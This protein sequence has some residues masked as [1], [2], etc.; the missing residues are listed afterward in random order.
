MPKHTDIRSVLIIGSGPIVIGQACEFDYSGTQACRALRKEGYRVILQNSNPATIMTD[1]EIADATY[2][3]P[4]IP[5]A[6]RAIIAKERPDALL[7]TLGGQTALNL[8]HALWED[9][10]LEEFGVRLLGASAK[11]IQLAEDRLEFKQAVLDAGLDVPASALVKTLQEAEAAAEQLGFP[12]VVRPSYTLGGQGG[13]IAFNRDE[14]REIVA[15]GLAASPVKSVLLEESVL[16][17]KEY[18]LE[19][20][21][22]GADNGVVV[23]TIENFDPMGV[24]TGDSITVAPAQ[25]LTDREYQALRDA[26]LTVLRVLGVATGGANVQFAVHPG[27]GRMVVI[28][29][30]P[31]VSR[32]SALASKATGF[33]IAKIAALLAMGYR[34]DE[35]PNEITE[36]TPACFEPTLDYVVVKMPRFAFDKF[37]GTSTDLGTQMKSVGEVMAIGRTFPEALGK[38]LRS[39][40]APRS[41]L[42]YFARSGW[43][44]DIWRPLLM[45]P[46]ADRL[47][48]LVAAITSGC[49]TEELTNLTGIDPWFITQLRGALALAEQTFGG[50]V[51]LFAQE[52]R[53][54]IPWRALKQNGFSDRELAE[55]WE[56][57]ESDVRHTREKANV[58][59]V[60]KTVDTCA[61]EFAASTPYFYS[62]YE[63]ETEAVRLGKKSVVIL[64]SGP[65]RIGQGVEFDYCCVRAVYAFK[66]AGYQTI[67]VNSNPETVSTDYDTS[68]RLYFE[69]LTAEDVLSV[70]ARE[71]PYGVVVQLGGQTPLKLAGELRKA[72]YRLLGTQVEAIDR[73]E[74]RARFGALL[75]RLNIPQVPA[76]M[77]QDRQA[78]ARLVRKLGL[79]V[80]VR[81]SYVLGG[82]AMRVIYE[83]G[84]A[85]AYV[86]E[87]LERYPDATLQ[88][89]RFL[90]DAIEADVDAVSDGETTFVAGIMEHIEEAG[91]HSGDS[92]CVT[93]PV[94][95]SPEV[96]ARMRV[97]TRQIA[98][99]LG[100]KGLLNIQF[101]IKGEQV[102]VL[103]ANPRASR[104][105]P[106][107]SKATGYP[108]IDWAVRVMTGERL[109]GLVP[110]TATEPLHMSVKM[111]VF[112]FDRFPGADVILGPQMR[113]TGEAMGID[114]DFGRA[115]AKGYY[116]LPGGLP[117][118]GTAFVSVADRH[119]RE[120]TGL[121]R[122][123]KDLGF[124]LMATPGTAQVL[125]RFGI[126]CTR[127][128]KASEMRPNII[129]RLSDG[130]V[131]LV[132]NVPEGSRPYQDS[133]A[134]RRTAL[135]KNIPCITTMAGAQAAITGIAAR[136]KRDLDVR[137]LQEY[138]GVGKTEVEG[139]EV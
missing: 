103:E 84:A 126:E 20:M 136:Q 99:A 109:A 60:F 65:N 71:K 89:D 90:E 23:C 67:L 39:L 127:V 131:T 101:A 73:A 93:P 1:P 10:T 104:T 96:Q 36:A 80:L 108:I 133:M 107:I 7:P 2:I 27:T 95:L 119:K 98:E 57:G 125:E 87:V 18:E 28:E 61:G 129:D 137:S 62:C 15:G 76:G 4:L 31:R 94:S 86:A 82:E 130:S 13:G 55:A 124:K 83:A 132:V 92:V 77:A 69:P 72:G 47:K 54:E 63:S 91:I 6:A 97:Y 11:T 32:S 19:V 40:E 88:I 85:D 139:V 64:S 118:G 110:A 52:M 123:L 111:P 102:Y 121:A 42:L 38:A 138:L 43:T 49:T 17:W 48:A 122:S 113:S 135:A 78:A 115:L 35:L 81:P 79:P 114:L 14:L 116:A 34:L 45:R 51:D 68:D 9:G 3:E 50:Q 25:T 29:A 112:P 75:T 46:N 12:L 44:E 33:P 22:D 30:N 66:E 8:A 59:P 134:I 58:Y 105:V 21:R 74:D 100:V 56:T 106:F 37:P 24:H 16:G 5:A 70:C 41:G 120:V 53:A 26:A 128:N 117:Q